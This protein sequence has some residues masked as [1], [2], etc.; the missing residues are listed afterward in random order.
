MKSADELRE[1]RELTLED[2]KKREREAA[3]ELF[4]LRFRKASGQLDR[5]HRI[6]ELRRTR[7]RVKTLLRERE[8]Q[9]AAQE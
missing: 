2:L 7:A 5:P 4:R 6:G 3:E 9:E 8:G 1:L